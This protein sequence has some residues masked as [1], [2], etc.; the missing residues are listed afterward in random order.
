MTADTV[1]HQLGAVHE[2]VH[3]AHDAADRL[4]AFVDA[5]EFGV[6]KA[7]L[8][9][10]SRRRDTLTE[11]IDALDE[12]RVGVADAAVQMVAFAVAFDVAIDELALCGRRNERACRRVRRRAG[13]EGHARGAYPG[14]A[15]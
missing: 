12:A 2:C 11:H 8:A 7:S 15:G 9:L 14:N 4:G 13:R 5:V 6:P 10:R 1:I 3:D